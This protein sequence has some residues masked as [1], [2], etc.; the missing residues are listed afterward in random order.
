MNFLLG[1]F[2]KRV[3]R[4]G[5]FKS[6]IG[7]DS[8]QEISSETGVK[9][10]KLSISKRLSRY[11]EREGTIFPHTNINKHIWI[12]DEKTHSQIDNDLRDKRVYSNINEV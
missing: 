2:S 3:G 9:V 12:Y 1:D 6:T 7:N 11:H 5:I 4:E 10:A 8:S